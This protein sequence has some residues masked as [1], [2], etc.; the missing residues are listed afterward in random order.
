[1]SDLGGRLLWMAEHKGIGNIWYIYMTA[2]R[3][4]WCER[5]GTCAL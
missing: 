1:V 5:I 4:L 2:A 3:F